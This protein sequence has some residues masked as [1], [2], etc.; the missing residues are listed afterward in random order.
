MR[1]YK[2]IP[3]GCTG[4]WEKPDGGPLIGRDTCIGYDMSIMKEGDTYRMWYSSAAGTISH[5]T[6]TDGVHWELPTCVL[7]RTL[8]SSW[9]ESMVSR[10]RVIKKDGLYHMW[11]IGHIFDNDDEVGCG[12][13]GY[14]TS[15]DGIV[16]ETLPEPVLVP[17]LPWEQ[18]TIFCPFVQ[19]EEE[20]GLFKMWY[21]AGEQRDADSIGYATSRDG[22]HWE[23]Y[24]GNP[25]LS[26][27]HENYW[28]MMKVQCADVHRHSDGY[29][30]LFYI[31]IDGDWHAS[32][33][34][35][36]SKDGITGWERHPDNPVIAGTDGGW[37]YI[38]VYRPAVL[39]TEDG[40]WLY[41]NAAFYM[42]RDEREGRKVSEAIGRAVHKG[43]DLWPEENA[44]LA[45]NLPPFQGSLNRM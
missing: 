33:N 30:Y 23:K 9:Q 44:K 14:G 10:P 25:I 8:G 1:K 5:A 29:Y 36:R 38:C 43:F 7:N 35:A 39:Q 22:I 34:L 6:S 3:R 20:S 32:I 12:S 13:V 17:E 19:W 26:R 15:K 42:D 41:Y 45:R 31:G 27:V 4:G 37:D 21:S 18:R 28:E 11:Y 2:P 24:A 40:Y 16:W